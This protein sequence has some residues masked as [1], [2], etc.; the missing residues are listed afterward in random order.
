MTMLLIATSRG[1]ICIDE[2]SPSAYLIDRDNRSY[3]GITYNDK[4]IY[5]A[6]R[7]VSYAK[8]KGKP[9]EHPGVILVYDFN[10][11][12]VDELLPHFPLRDL[13]QI[14]FFNNKLWAVCT[15]DSMIAV[16]EDGVWDRW[17]PLGNNVHPDIKR[18]YHFN[19]IYNY[20]NRIYIAGSIDRNGIIYEYDYES[21]ALLNRHFAGYSSHNVWVRNGVISTLSSMAGAKLSLDGSNEIISRGNFVRGISEL[22]S[23]VYYGISTA[24]NRANREGANLMIKKVS[25]ENNDAYFYGIQ[26]FGQINEIRSPGVFDYAHPAHMGKMIQAGGLSDRFPGVPVFTK[27]IVREIPAWLSAPR[28]IYQR[29]DMKR[30]KSRLHKEGIL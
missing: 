26:D 11:E 16:H 8:G 1:F 24:K 6:A 18:K 3:Y 7:R 22:E 29:F 5:V 13:H 14:Y 27:P 4:N 28:G 10:L 19:S 21:R 30:R 15:Y 25:I 9:E 17:Y 12:L 20:K 2:K 23:A